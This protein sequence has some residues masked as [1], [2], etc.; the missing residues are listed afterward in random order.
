MVVMVEVEDGVNGSKGTAKNA[1]G[2]VR[3]VLAGNMGSQ[4]SRGIS[5]KVKGIQVGKATQI[6]L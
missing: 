6:L 1:Y 3:K 4:H 5:L 2:Y